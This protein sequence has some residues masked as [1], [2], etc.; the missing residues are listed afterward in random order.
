VQR[1]S[2]P[3]ERAPRRWQERFLSWFDG[4]DLLITPATA[5]GPFPAGGPRG[6]RYTPTLLRSAVR[7]PYTPAWNLAGLPALVVPVL[8]G[9]RPVGVQL[10]GRPGDEHRLLAVGA[11]L[12]QHAVP[13]TAGAPRRVYTA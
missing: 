9:G 7:T 11:R 2:R 8:V 3:G 6:R 10:V 5:T 13:T 12:E 1:L 4:H